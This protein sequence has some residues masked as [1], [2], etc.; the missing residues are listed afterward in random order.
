MKVKRMG[1]IVLLI[2]THLFDFYEVLYVTTS[3]TT[4]VLQSTTLQSSRLRYYTIMRLWSMN[5]PM[6]YWPT[7]CR[8]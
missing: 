2:L 7:D 3:T 8:T 1:M 5:K 6:S 4:S